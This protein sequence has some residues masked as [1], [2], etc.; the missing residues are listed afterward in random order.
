EPEG[1]V[2]RVNFAQVAL[3]K[4]ELLERAAARFRQLSK[5]HPLQEELAEFTR[6]N[7]SWLERHVQFMSL[8]E[9]NHGSSWDNWSFTDDVMTSKARH[10]HDERKQVH[11]IQQFLFFRQWNFLKQ[12]ATE[13]GIQF[14]GDVPIYV[15]HDSADVWGNRYLFQLDEQGRSISVAGV[16]PDYFATTGQ[17]WK[18]PLYDWSAMEH[19]GYRWWI[20]RLHNLLKL[21]DLVRLDHFR[22]FEAY[23]SVPATESTA[24][25][26]TWIDGP[27]DSFLTAIKN[28][29][30]PGNNS[31]SNS[32]HSIPIIAE[33]LGMITEQVHSLRRRF[34]LPGMKVLQFMLPGEAWDNTTS[35][36]FEPNS[37]VYTG[38]HD[39]DTTLG[40]FRSEILP[41]GEKLH[42]LKRY[43]R[44]HEENFPWEFI[45][46]AWHSSSNLAIAPLQ[47]VMSLDSTARMNTP[48]TS[49]DL[50]TNW[51]WTFSP[52]RL[53]DS[54]MHQLA[55]VTRQANR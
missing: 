5:M 47:D 6:S 15:S 13:L 8:R 51:Q 19:E 28:G 1:L 25:N 29:L 20:S 22:G 33:D 10:H 52:E 27:R 3:R 11:G 44:C 53:T 7:Q 40:W 16:P 45:D 55:H 12:R 39:N 2:R 35:E 48:G 9:L 46:F 21:V 38:T 36:D 30:S 18:N 41:N 32:D 42:R 4:K 26:G 24:I 50:T 54:L 37:V 34:E 23:W 14:I 43:V 31:S 17:L 49:G